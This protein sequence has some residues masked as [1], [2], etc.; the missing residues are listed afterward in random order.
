M[1][2][3]IENSEVKD[4]IPVLRDYSSDLLSFNINK[5]TVNYTGKSNP[6]IPAVT[7]R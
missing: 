3:N 5:L 6:S 7:I 4:E 1:I 2:F